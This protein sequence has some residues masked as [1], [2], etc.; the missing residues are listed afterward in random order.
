MTARTATES[1]A[2]FVAGPGVG[3]V[4]GFVAAAQRAKL[5]LR[6]G[7]G[8]YLDAG[9]VPK[10]DP[11]RDPLAAKAEADRA[12]YLADGEY[13]TKI[14]AGD[15]VAALLVV[16]DGAV[17]QGFAR[18]AGAIRSWASDVV[19]A[20]KRGGFGYTVPDL[21]DHWDAFAEALGEDEAGG[22]AKGPAEATWMRW[23]VGAVRT[24]ANGYARLWRVV[25]RLPSSRA[26]LHRAYAYVGDAR[27]GEEEKEIVE[28]GLSRAIAAL[29]APLKTLKSDDFSPPDPFSTAKKSGFATEA[30]YDAAVAKAYPGIASIRAA[31]AAA[32]A[33][34][35][36]QAGLFTKAAKARVAALPKEPPKKPPMRASPTPWTPGGALAKIAAAATA[37][38][39]GSEG[40]LAARGFARKVVVAAHPDGSDDRATLDH[41]V[42]RLQSRVGEKGYPTE[43]IEAWLELAAPP[44]IAAPSRYDLYVDGTYIGSYPPK[45]LPEA[46]RE[47]QR[48]K[49]EGSAVDLRRVVQGEMPSA[50]PPPPPVVSRWTTAPQGADLATTATTETASEG[51]FA[52]RRIAIREDSLDAQMD[53]YVAAA[54]SEQMFVL[55]DVEFAEWMAQIG[56]VPSEPDPSMAAA[57]EAAVPTAPSPPSVGTYGF[58]VSNAAFVDGRG[59]VAAQATGIAFQ[60]DPAGGPSVWWQTDDGDWYKF[61]PVEGWLD[62]GLDGLY[63]VD[64]ANPEGLLSVWAAQGVVQRSNILAVATLPRAQPVEVPPP[65]PALAKADA[66]ILAGQEALT[67]AVSTT[68]QDATMDRQRD[69]DAIVLTWGG[70]KGTARVVLTPAKAPDRVSIQASVT[71]SAMTFAYTRTGEADA[72]AAGDPAVLFGTTLDDAATTLASRT[73]AATAISAA[74]IAAQAAEIDPEVGLSISVSSVIRD[75]IAPAAAGVYAADRGLFPFIEPREV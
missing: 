12:R 63:L 70:A 19:D 22:S 8:A 62:G 55:T 1:V 21:R 4:V 65:D 49:D 30:E 61:V 67:A 2:G 59:L 24:E 18:T 42:A 74:A 58:D 29:D 37:R 10:G 54:A 44:L 28:R 32:E 3:P 34:A 20:I 57:V 53:A 75:A 38:A 43:W 25:L 35:A 60:P 5:L 13:L 48:Y 68:L 45:Q 14:A 33:C 40:T 64:G 56:A 52:W 11:R 73:A 39:E 47:A 41:L 50:P 46:A 26:I 71:G 6:R 51:G 72:D 15:L 9:G 23:A 31:I 36:G 7:V 17:A 16:G 27:C 66:A 69:A